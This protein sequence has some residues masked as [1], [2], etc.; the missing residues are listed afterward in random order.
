MK[1]NNYFLFNLKF[2]GTPEGFVMNAGTLGFSVT[3]FTICAVTTLAFLMVRRSLAIF[4]NAELGG[5][6]MPK[7]ITFGFFIMLWII[8]VLLSSLQTYEVIAGF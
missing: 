6:D 8:Y 5:P 4:G 7:Y 2:Q 3:I 1:I